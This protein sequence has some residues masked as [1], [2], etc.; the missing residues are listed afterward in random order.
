VTIETVSSGTLSLVDQQ[1]EGRLQQR[2]LVGSFIEPDTSI[3]K[4]RLA[5]C[6][7]GWTS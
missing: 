6:C 2:Q 5:G 3:R 1:A 7:S 4:T